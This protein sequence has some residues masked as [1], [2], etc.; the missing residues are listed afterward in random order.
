MTPPNPTTTVHPIGQHR[1]RMIENIGRDHWLYEGIPE[2]YQANLKLNDES[3]VIEVYLFEW[4]KIPRDVQAQMVR[5]HALVHHKS[6]TE[7]F[8]YCTTHLHA[9][10]CSDV[11]LEVHEY[12]QFN[13][14]KR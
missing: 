11:R 8:E 13:R 14:G 9:I 12:G 3:K 2:K 5:S 7:A 6:L 4:D 10:P 1:A